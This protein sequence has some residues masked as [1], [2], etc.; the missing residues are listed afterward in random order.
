LETREGSAMQH[1]FLGPIIIGLVALG[2]LSF[3]SVIIA[4]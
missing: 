1:D 3:L 2:Y 4:G